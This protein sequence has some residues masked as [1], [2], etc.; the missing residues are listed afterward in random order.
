MVPF[1][2]NELPGE[3]QLPLVTYIMPLVYEVCNLTYY[4]SSGL[5]MIQRLVHNPPT[6]PH[7]R[8]TSFLG[9]IS[10]AFPKVFYKPIFSCAAANKETTVINQLVVLNALANFVPDLWTRDPEMIVFALTSDSSASQ[11][12]DAGSGP[13]WG[14]TRVGQSALLLEIINRLSIVRNSK[15]M[16]QVSHPSPF[17]KSFRGL[18]LR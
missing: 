6:S 13:I 12:R 14:K 16:L 2:L 10:E 7:P 8:L 5:I 15:D 18:R 17:L 3:V 1:V 4:K 9:A 11:S